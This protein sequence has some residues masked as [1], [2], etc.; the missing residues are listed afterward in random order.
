MLVKINFPREIVV[1]VS[2]CEVL[3]NAAVRSL[4]LIPFFD[5]LFRRFFRFRHKCFYIPYSCLA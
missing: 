2:L 3:F 5:L 1:F 4:V